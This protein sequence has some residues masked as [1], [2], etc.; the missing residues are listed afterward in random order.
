[1]LPDWAC[2][3]RPHHGALNRLRRRLR[4]ATLVIYLRHPKVNERFL[5]GRMAHTQ[6][7]DDALRR[8]RVV[9]EGLVQ[10]VGFRPFVST[11]ARELGL[12]GFVGND[13]SGVFIEVE[14]PDRAVASFLD[15]LSHEPPRLARIDCLRVEPLAPLGVNTFTIVASSKSLSRD[16][17]VTA[18]AG[19]CDDCLREIRDPHDRR[20]AYPFTNCT[21]C[22]PRYTIIRDVPYDRA[23]TTMSPFAM[24]PRCQ[25]EYDDPDDRRYHAQP[26]CCPDC[27]P[28]LRL[29]NK[30]GT[31]VSEDP[32]AAVAERLTRGEIVAVKGLGGYHL[33]VDACNGAAVDQLRAGKHREER[34]FALIVRDLTAAREI[35][36]INDDEVALLTSP[37]RPIVLLRRRTN[38]AL[39]G[40]VAP[41]TI[42]LGVMLPY[43]A[44]H[45]LLLDQLGGPLVLT[46]GNVSD[47]PITFD[48]EDAVRRLSPI[49]DVFLTHNREIETRVDD[50][51]AR[52]VGGE[53]VLIRRSRGYAPAPLRV[54]WP[55]PRPVLA[56]GAELKNTFCL[57]RGH[58]AFLSHH[59]GDLENYETFASFSRG[60]EHLQRLFAISPLVVAHDL[61]PDYV[62]TK[63]ATEFDGVELVGVQHHHAHIAS[64]LADNDAAG[65]VIGV[66]F[67]GT[68][69]GEDGTVW[70]GEFLIADLATSTRAAHLAPV[71]LPGG[72]AAIREPWRMAASYLAEAFP[73]GLPAQQDVERRHRD[74]W[75]A[76]SS[77]MDTRT[78]SPLTSSAG[79][80]FDAVAALLDVR[81]DVMYEGQAAIELEQ[82]ADPEETGSYTATV[83]DD[84]IPRVH[85]AD[86]VRD[87]VMDRGAHVPTS[88][89]AARFHHGVSA[90][91]VDVCRKLRTRH[92]LTTVALSGGVFQNL[93]LLGETTQLLT[94][95]GFEVLT[96]HRVPTNDGGI[97]LGQA[98]VVGA[99]DRAAG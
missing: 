22:G 93:L 87:V 85:A 52:S 1:M 89:I 79:R 11:R 32:I 28:H 44:L 96:H 12:S 55:F 66:A 19:T 5:K 72:A 99:Q 26:L 3:W 63:Y 60:V 62:S 4:V 50:S 61:H 9:V 37:A 59:I 29:V 78:N 2:E 54:R 68:G 71:P 46:S 81:D 64:C 8:V 47:E 49:A 20:F 84:E 95:A 45:H 23:N 10:G 41:R 65:P 98:M 14:G 25:A 33:A 40:A 92:G 48:D 83:S 34:P 80:L 70:G 67:D 16:A 74:R 53:T 97:S 69:F 77:M 21:N 90:M 15:A 35:C 73:D 7:V 42:E 82:L 39:A 56:C 31:V 43:T 17:L 76:V 13:T 94:E 36:F 30:T 86:L 51:V 38:A 18:D 58:D 6:G 88:V 27:G 24:C 75:A 91:I 57:G